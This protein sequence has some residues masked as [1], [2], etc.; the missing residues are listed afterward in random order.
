VHNLFTVATIC[1]YWFSRQSPWAKLPKKLSV[2]VYFWQYD[3][4]FWLRN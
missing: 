2:G 1:G 3:T 4:V